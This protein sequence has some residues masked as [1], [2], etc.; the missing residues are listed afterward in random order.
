ME[1][2]QNTDILKKLPH[3]PP[4]LMVDR[5]LKLEH[6]CCKTVKNISYAEPCF[7][8]HF[9]GQPVFPGVLIIE[10]MAQTCSLCLCEYSGNSLPIFAGIESARFR[11]PVC[12]GD[13]LYMD[14]YFQNQK[15]NFYTF[16]ATARTDDEVACEATLTIYFKC[17]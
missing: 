4:M 10:A 1:D 14:A 6:Y 5:I 2:R 9:P 3:R 7:Q 17:S 13:Q 16:I 8:G 11:K 12:P 15:N